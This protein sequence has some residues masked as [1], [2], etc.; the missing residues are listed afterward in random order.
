MSNKPARYWIG[1]ISVASGWSVPNDIPNGAT[2]IRG[3]R[4]IGAGGFEHFQLFAAFAKPVRF[5]QVQRLLSCPNS[6]W[7][8]SKSKAAE[9][10]V[11]KED[12]RVE[13]SQFEL[14]SKP[15]QRNS[16]KDWDSI[17]K[18]AERGDFVSIPSD[19][20]IRCFHQIRSI[21]QENSVAH[22]IVRTCYVF[23]GRTGTGKSRKAWDEAGFDAYCK[24]PRTKWFCGYRGEKNVIID[25]FRG[26]IDISHMLRWLD[27][28]PVRVE[29][30]GGSRPLC[31]EKIWITSNLDPREW[32]PELDEETKGALLRRLNI[33]HFA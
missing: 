15:M 23:W 18:S 9:E 32:Y 21:A 19:I 8:A 14:G 7:E 33:T 20:Y 13:G 31:A 17:R 5:T 24:D 29:T 2:W 28:Y 4:E 25:E 27:R 1:T 12:T 22:P 3:Q 26:S 6:H 11:W 10:Y 16:A 30:K